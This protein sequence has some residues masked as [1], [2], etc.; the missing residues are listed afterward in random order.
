MSAPIPTRLPTRVQAAAALSNATGESYASILSKLTGDK[1]FVW[2]ARQ[3]PYERSEAVEALKLDGVE[4]TREQRRFYPDH[5]MAAQVLGF[6][7]I[8]NQG[9]N[10]LE[11]YYNKIL[12]GKKGLEL[13]ERDARGRT[14]MADNKSVKAE[15]D[16]LSI[17]TTIDKTIQHVAQVELQKAFDKFRCKSASVVVMDPATGEILAMANYPTFDPNHFDAY[18]AASWKNRVVNDQF[19]PGSTFK[20]VAAAAALE[21]GIVSEDDKFFCENGAYKTEYGRVVTDHESHGWLTFR[22]VFG[23]SSNIGMVKVGMKLGK[24]SLYRYCK[25]FGFGD[26]TGIDL[27][28]ET[29]GK[30]RPPDEVERPFHGVHSLWL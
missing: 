28:G 13:T 22:E 26:L 19:E 11:N 1:A 24:D 25:K 12:T 7:G 5:E 16:G 20:L 30:L 6:T 4:A 15:K 27:P 10:G 9:L 18:P 14:V 8:D 17:V 23:F 21:E 2:I 3:V 29:P